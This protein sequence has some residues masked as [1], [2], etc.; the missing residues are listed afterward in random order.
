VGVD[1]TGYENNQGL[2]QNLQSTMTG[3]RLSGP[4]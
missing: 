2:L 4:I 1:M 3:P